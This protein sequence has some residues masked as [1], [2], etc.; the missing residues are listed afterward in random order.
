MPTSNVSDNRFPGFCRRLWSA[1]ILLLCFA[2]MPLRAG[3]AVILVIDISN[4]SAVTFT[5][6][7]AFAQNDDDDSFSISGISLIDFFQ[8]SFSDSDLHYF[9]SSNL[10][11]P[12]GD[13]PYSTLTSIAFFDPFSSEYFDLS[14]F[15]DSFS[16]QGFSTSAPALTGSAVAN[17]SAWLAYLPTAGTTG[18]IHSGDGIFSS[19]PVIGQYSVV[20]EP[21]TAGLLLGATLLAIRRARRLPR[22]ARS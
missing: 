8:A 3:A 4:P 12:E 21:A 11:S 18:N 2:L 13:F 16:G 10:R 14:I 9:S 15:Y 1:A 17:L 20:P 19:G 6:T 7:G 22:M 5:A